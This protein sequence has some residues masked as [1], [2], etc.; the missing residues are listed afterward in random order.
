MTLSKIPHFLGCI[1]LHWGFKHWMVLKACQKISLTILWAQIMMCIHLARWLLQMCQS[2]SSSDS[3]IS[4]IFRDCRK[5]SFMLWYL[6]K[7]RLYDLSAIQRDMQE[8][9]RNSTL[10]R[11]S[12]STYLIWFCWCEVELSSA[13]PFDTSPLRVFVGLQH[14]WRWSP[15][16]SLR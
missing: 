8:L 12:H 11:V 3:L 16:C 9:P 7:L 14:S 10:H 4:D 6:C 15:C 2:S 5:I 1:W 13:H